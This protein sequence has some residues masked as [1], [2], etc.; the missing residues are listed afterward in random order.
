MLS[1]VLFA[2]LQLFYPSVASWLSAL[3][4]LPA[5][6]PVP[7]ALLLSSCALCPA[8]CPPS[9]LPASVCSP[10]TSTVASS[11]A[12]WAARGA[13]SPVSTAL[14]VLPSSA[15]SPG[16]PVAAAVVPLGSSWPLGSSSDFVLPSEGRV[17]LSLSHSSDCS[18]SAAAAAAAA[19]SLCS[20][21]GNRS[22]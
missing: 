7:S 12:S 5:C 17:V 13:S 15:A 16:A 3:L 2:F 1:P 22:V 19:L 20:P 14:S 21:L 9:S 18:S 6:S 4:V 11:A 8:S 10:G